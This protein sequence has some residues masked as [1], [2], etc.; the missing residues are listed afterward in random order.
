MLNL[1]WLFFCISGGGCSSA[2][3]CGGGSP[4]YF[5]VVVLLHI[6]RWSMTTNFAAVVSCFCRGV[7]T[8]DGSF[9]LVITSYYRAYIIGIKS[10]YS[11]EFTS[12]QFSVTLHRFL[13]ISR[14]LLEQEFSCGWS[15]ECRQTFWESKNPV[16]LGGCNSY[17]MGAESRSLS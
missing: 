13:F 16:L 12:L 6:V 10:F 14:G 15:Q 17:P 4:A 11:I 9:Y 1:R 5:A 3:F 2:Y 8:M 7:L